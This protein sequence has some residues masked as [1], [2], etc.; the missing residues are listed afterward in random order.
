MH[1]Q[2]FVDNGP[3]DIA[4]E[5]ADSFVRSHFDPG[6]TSV[7]PVFTPRVLD[8]PEGLVRVNVTTA[9]ATVITSGAVGVPFCV[10]AGLYGRVRVSFSVIVTVRI[11]VPAYENHRVVH[12][13][14]WALSSR[15][16]TLFVEHESFAAGID[17]DS[18]WLFLDGLFDRVNIVP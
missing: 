16:D 9:T 3:C 7:A 2:V 6:K 5:A 8:E 18:D 4:I 12:S 13:G 14:L 10:D 11:R 1:E 15:D 17:T